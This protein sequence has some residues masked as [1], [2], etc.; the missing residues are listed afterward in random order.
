MKRI[1]Y[2]IVT[3]LLFVAILF[4]AG[5]EQE[6]DPDI[7]DNIVGTYN[8]Q[9]TNYY[10]ADDGELVYLEDMDDSG[11]ISI[12]KNGSNAR[13]IDFMQN[14]TL[15]FQGLHIASTSEGLRFSLS[16]ED[17]IHEGQ[18]YTLEGYNHWK[19]DDIKFQ[20]VYIMNDKTFKLSYKL[21][22]D[23]NDFIMIYEGT[24]Q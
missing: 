6:D 4:T 7:R 15:Q 18:T 17:F 21:P 16:S 14:G 24:K 2:L 13:T 20:G 9:L 11:V 3:N 5:C 8:Y 12:E 22:V 19:V 1:S 23:G 10:L